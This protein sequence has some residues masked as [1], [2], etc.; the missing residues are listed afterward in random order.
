M[1]LT[2]DQEEFIRINQPLTKD[3]IELTRAV[4]RN[5]S[6]DGRTQEGRAV[7]AFLIKNSLDYSTTKR[8]KV[9]DI[10]LTREQEEFIAQYSS[11]GMNSFEIAN[12]IFRD[13]E[14]KKLGKEQRVVLEYLDEHS[15]DLIN[16]M[17]TAVEDYVPPRTMGR[18][19][20]KINE[21]DVKSLSEDKLTKNI[22]ECIKKLITYLSSPRFIATI[23][24]Y[25]S[26]KDRD[27][28]EAEFIRTVWEKPDLTNDEI[29]LYIN[30]CIEYIN[31][32]NINK[33]IEKLNMMFDRL[34]EENEMTVRLAEI[35]KAK[36]TEYDQCEKR[37]RAL[38]SVLN[39]DRAKRIANKIEKNASILS[40]VQAFQAEEDRKFMIEIA[41]RQKK[42]VR[43]EA[44]RIEDMDSWKARVLGIDKRDLM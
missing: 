18:A 3:L 13:V 42:L 31:L 15:P 43:K 25:G 7:K 27:L 23:N 10:E 14:V 4:F 29:N 44:D 26:Q 36:S 16:E 34:E 30:V 38:I 28:F 33:H 39:G 12:V 20:K 21:Y 5:D 6:L 11:E 2:E 35:L 37:Q 19:I 9:P 32:K 22:N 40:L 24:N 17:D 1:N 41:E 8:E